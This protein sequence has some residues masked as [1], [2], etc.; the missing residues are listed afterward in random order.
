MSDEIRDDRS[1]SH[2]D[3]ADNVGNDAAPGGNNSKKTAAVIAGVLAIVT[4]VVVGRSSCGPDPTPPPP[5]EAGVLAQ[6]A[7][8]QPD[9]AEPVSCDSVGPRSQ[10][11]FG[12]QAPPRIVG[13]TVASEGQYPYAVAIATESRFQYC[14]GTLLSRRHVLTAAHCQVAVGDLA[15]VES[16]DLTKGRAVTITESRIHR[17]FDPSTLDYDVAIAVLA[18]DVNAGTVPLSPDAIPLVATAIGWGAT[19]E[20]GATTTLL[21]QVDV[22]IW[23]S[24]DCRQVYPTLTSRQICAGKVEGGADSCQGDSGG[25]LLVQA[26]GLP[27]QLGVVSFGIGCA[28]PGVPGVYTDLRADEIRSW[29]D[30]CAR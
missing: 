27:R 15:L 20:G 26:N 12:V 30:A 4:S 5:T 24:D 25:A 9:T 2:A 6:D 21:R 3:D 11:A 22:P 29:I 16:A 23:S 28:R 7:T 17:S 13:G 19:T 10:R 1:M 8:P 18:E 14:A